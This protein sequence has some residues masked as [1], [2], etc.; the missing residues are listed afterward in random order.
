MLYFDTTMAQTL[1]TQ[2]EQTHVVRPRGRA[3]CAL[4]APRRRTLSARG[5]CAFLLVCLLPCAAAAYTIVM[6]SGRRVEAPGNFKVTPTTL[7]YEA[8]PGLSVT[9]QLAQIDIAA[10]ERANGEPSGSL[11]RRAQAFAQ[12]QTPRSSPRVARTL[13][14]RELEPLRRARVES[15]RASEERRK[16]L[17][18]PSAEEERRAA[19]AQ[20]RALR[21]IARRHEAEV[22]QS[23]SYWRARAAALRAETAVLDAEIDYLR[24]RVSESSDYFSPGAVALVTT[25]GPLFSSRPFILSPGRLNTSGFGTSTQ[26]GGRLTFGGGQTRG[27]IV[28]NQ[29]ETA[30]TFRRRFIGAPGLFASPVA[31]LAV[32]FNY[33]TANAAAL[34]VRLAELEAARAGLDA[35]RQQLEDEA[36]RAGALPGWLRP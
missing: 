21:E 8:A 19:Q 35:R 36:R 29:R 32:P 17:G 25:V 16:A 3:A 4:R 9:L 28:F 5:L 31:V 11:L 23:E 34:R 14:N 12:T 22:A 30:G 18:L 1:R 6:R 2:T 20:E 33:A 26:L 13:T 24:T 15:E 27:Q 10:T 7:T